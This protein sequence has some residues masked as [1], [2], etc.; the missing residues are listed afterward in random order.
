[1]LTF[2]IS[3]YQKPENKNTPST[4]HPA[5]AKAHEEN[6][7]FSM[8]LYYLLLKKTLSLFWKIAWYPVLS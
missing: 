4:G 1:M 3:H 5:S 7:P 6:W 2:G 8:T